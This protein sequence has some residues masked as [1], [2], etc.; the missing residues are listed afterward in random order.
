MTLQ[1]SLSRNSGAVRPGFTLVELLVVIAIIGMLIALLL[2]AVQAARAAANRAACSNNMK[3]LGLALHNFHDTQDA[4]PPICIYAKRPTALML[5][6]PYMEQTALHDLVNGGSPDITTVVRELSGD[7]NLQGNLY[8]KATQWDDPRVPVI[9]DANHCWL[10]GT[11]SGRNSDDARRRLA[12]TFAVA[13][14][15]CPASNAN[16]L[17]TIEGR[18]RG[19]LAD[20]VA[21]VAKHDSPTNRNPG[22][23]WWHNYNI[24]REENNQR[25][26][27]TYVGPLRLPAL[28]FSGSP[29]LSGA[30]T[31]IAWARGITDWKYNDTIAYWATRGTSNQLVFSEKHVPAH[32][33]RAH[34]A[35][36]Q[37][38]WNGNYMYTDGTDNAHNVGR[39]VSDHADTF[40]SSPSEPA[41]ASRINIGPQAVEGRYTIGSGHS[42]VVNMVLGDGSVRGISKTTAPRLVWDLTNAV[43]SATVSLP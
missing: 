23:G 13:A 31:G 14:Y 12:T 35:G 4:L 11:G 19:P 2:P 32:T 6:W 36:Q 22:W 43:D 20:Y 41:T 17:F 9:D 10:T 1:L 15:R 7:A 3:Q 27:S 18:C 5:L 30:D 28:T 34:Q 40:A 37:S 29:A 42:S 24:Y 25:H 21:L 33:L 38:Q 16:T 39:I 26:R 8:Q